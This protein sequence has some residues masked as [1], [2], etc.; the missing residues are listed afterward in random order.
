MSSTYVEI[1]NNNQS[2]E[3]ARNANNFEGHVGHENFL[4]L[5]GIYLCAQF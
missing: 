1:I 5:L 3:V 4:I 2:K